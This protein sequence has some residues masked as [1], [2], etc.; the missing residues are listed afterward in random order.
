MIS[1]GR[2]SWFAAGLRMHLAAGLCLV[3]LAAAAGCENDVSAGDPNGLD[4]TGESTIRPAA[5]QPADPNS[6]PAMKPA[7]RPTGPLPPEAGCITAEC[8]AAMATARYVHGAISFGDCT[9][10]HQEDRGDHTYPLKR[11]GNASCTFC[12]ASRGNRLHE[13][14]AMEAPGCIACHRPHVSDTKFL[15]TARSVEALCVTCHVTDQRARGH[16][17][18]ATGECTT[19]HLPHE[20]DYEHLLRGGDGPDHCYMC[21]AETK[22]VLLNATHVHAPAGA[23][24]TICHSPHASEHEHA[25]RQS[26]EQTCFSCHEALEEKIAGST[27]PHA[28]V[29]TADRCANCHDPHAASWPKLLRDRQDV[30]C[31]QCH[32]EPIRA[33]D[34]RTIPNVASM[35]QGRVFLHGPVK[36]GDCA[37]CHNVHGASHARLLRER[38][39]ETFY[40]AFDPGNY[41]LCFSCHERELVTSARTTALTDFRD[42][43]L[44]LHFLHV[45]RQRKGR[46]CAACHAIH[47]SNLPKHLAE[48]V[49]FE[50]SGWTM[51]IGFK[52]TVTGGSCAP[53]CHEPLAYDRQ[54][55]PDPPTQD[56]AGGAP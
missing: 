14:A 36:A 54:V 46:T 32:D 33:A 8:H 3:L 47:G 7:P 53:G 24:C 19:C 17:P 28:A 9:V 49:R 2:Q 22:Y 20:S 38:F 42:G 18:F 29:F 34:G 43:D 44:N 52:K 27:A 15:L 23:D 25:L 35:L 11:Q 55:R 56:P 51:P 37:A 26:I 40:A 4:T 41:A 1:G 48:T 50:G 31:L 12:H 16:E 5:G 10:C 6:A 45:N 30:L 13:H 21:H 39:T